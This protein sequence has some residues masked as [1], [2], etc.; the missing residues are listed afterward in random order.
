MRDEESQSP[1]YFKGKS[2]E[3]TLILEMSQERDN[4]DQYKKSGNP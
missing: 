4:V 2:N 1:S 3:M